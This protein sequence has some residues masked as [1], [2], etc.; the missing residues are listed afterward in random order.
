M[1]VI[2]AAFVLFLV[3]LTAMAVGVLVQGKTLKG[4]CGGRGPD[5]RPLGDCLCSRE[6]QENCDL[7]Q[8]VEKLRQEAREGSLV[9]PR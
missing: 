5:G 9:G 7:K 1:Q 6:E 2:V 4:S 8:T 3:A